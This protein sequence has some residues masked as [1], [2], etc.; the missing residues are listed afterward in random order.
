[1][2]VNE[3]TKKNPVQFDMSPKLRNK[4]HGLV[5]EMVEKSVGIDYGT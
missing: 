4:V 3:K 2:L 5:L 1:M